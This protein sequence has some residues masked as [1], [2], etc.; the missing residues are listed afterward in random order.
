MVT[1]DKDLDF[2]FMEV[3]YY[4]HFCTLLVGYVGR[5]LCPVKIHLKSASGNLVR[6]LKICFYFFG[7]KNLSKNGLDE[8]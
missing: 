4:F 2:V 3:L 7:G 8:E 1:T 6:N 5:F